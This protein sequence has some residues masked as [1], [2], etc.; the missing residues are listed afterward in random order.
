MTH[1]YSIAII[2]GVISFLLLSG[3]AS[4]T[5]KITKKWQREKRIRRIKKIIKIRN[6]RL[7]WNLLGSLKIWI[8]N[9][10]PFLKL[11]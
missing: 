10:S 6:S 2:Y 11:I 7:L 5:F 9:Q 8:F 3:F 4:L 1:M